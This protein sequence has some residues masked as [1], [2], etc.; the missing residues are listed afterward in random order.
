MRK[1]H[2][3]VLALTAFA[4][5]LCCAQA[6]T[7]STPAAGASAG[8]PAVAAIP[9]DQQPSKEDV[10][11]FFEVMRL[12]QQMENM[13]KMMPGVIEQSYQAEI[14]N[15]NAQLPRGQRLSV[16]D[17]AA[18]DKV[19]KKYLDRA[20]NIYPVDEMIADAVPVYQRH[21][22]KADLEAVIAFYSS[23]AGQRL[24]DEQPVIMSEYMAV[25]MPQIQDRSKA[26]SRQMNAEMEQIVKP[27]LMDL[28]KSPVKSE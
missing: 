9:I 3:V 8:Q 16:Q 11:K 28:G 23:A 19:F 2:V 7:P 5:Q 12:R 6:A 1:I 21:I 18:I 25:L 24:L 27:E 20:M 13:M 15:I 26:L 4:A 14:G 10:E 22:S 17:Q